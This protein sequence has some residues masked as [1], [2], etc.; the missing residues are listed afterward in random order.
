MFNTYIRQD[1]SK[2]LNEAS[3][4]ISSQMEL[5][6][7][8]R[9]N[10]AQKE[11]KAR[12]RVDISLEEYEKMKKDIAWLTNQNTRYRCILEKIKIPYLDELD[13]DKIKIETAW[14]RD[15]NFNRILTIALT[16]DEEQLVNFIGK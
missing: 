2:G 15:F 14:H 7:I 16:I 3:L 1:Y 11:I 4:R 8:S 6:R 13:F 12:D 9:E 5:D 10:I